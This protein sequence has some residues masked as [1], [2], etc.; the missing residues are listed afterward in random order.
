MMKK[1]LIGLALVAIVGLAAGAF[2]LH[3]QKTDEQHQLD[4]QAAAQAIGPLIEQIDA[5]MA[6]T[7]PVSWVYD[8]EDTLLFAIRMSDGASATKVINDTIVEQIKAKHPEGVASYICR[9]YMID[10]LMSNKTDYFFER[11]VSLLSSQKSE[12]DLVR[13]LTTIANYGRVIGLENAAVEYF[14]KDLAHLTSWQVNFLMFAYKNED[15]DVMSYLTSAGMT[16]EQLDFVRS[17]AR[18][19]AFE[20]MLRAEIQKLGALQMSENSYTIKLSTS[21]AQQQAVQSSIDSA[22]KQ[23][24][25][26]ASNGSYVVNASV[27]VLNNQTGLITA[28]VPG[29]SSTT[30]EFQMNTGAWANNFGAL[31]SRVAQPGQTQYSLQTVRLPN[32]DTTFKGTGQQW[33]DQEL[34]TGVSNSSTAVDILQQLK[35]MVLSSTP[36]LIQQVKDLGGQVVYEAPGP[37]IQPANNNTVLK[38]RQCFTEQGS[39]Q[40]TMLS[41]VVK[42]SSG[43]VAFEM[44]SDYTVVILLGTGVIGGSMST[45]QRNGLDSV[46]ATVE[47]SVRAFFP[48][49]KTLMYARTEAMADEFAATYEANYQLLEK[50]L[51][52]QFE[53]LDAMV[54]NSVDSRKA[55]ET[56][57]ERLSAELK[58]LESFVSRQNYA[59]LV[60]DLY[61]IRQAKAEVILIYSV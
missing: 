43:V 45:D 50:E 5:T 47:E 30:E 61:E 10:N 38:L 36:S 22:M 20:A 21:A 53:K 4:E 51:G 29:R 34:A 14:S 9:Q 44:T 1:V 28:Y 42:L 55:F 11:F 18:N 58:S 16:Q 46:I 12:E 52:E 49:P 6:R 19:A 48:T 26:L 13:Y 57:Y 60:E 24:I 40:T 27:A 39:E 59:Q 37:Q 32:G 15:V 41:S 2:Y 7:T 56:E 54:I 35:V 33:L 17:D 31:I 3:T 8:S 23:Y 25:D